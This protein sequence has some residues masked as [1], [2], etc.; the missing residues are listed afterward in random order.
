MASNNYHF[1][2]SWHL[3]ATV[4][5]LAEI[6]RDPQSLTDWWAQCFLA[7]ET[8]D[9][10][11]TGRVLVRGFLPYTLQ[12]RFVITE[13][14]YP[15]RIQVEVEGD[16]E[17]RYLFTVEQGDGFVTLHVDTRLHVTKPV[18]RHL[19]WALK[20]LF[21]ANHR[22]CMERGMAN[23]REELARRRARERSSLRRVTL[24]TPA[25]PLAA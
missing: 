16:F 1:R 2:E 7:V 14:A 15:H 10:G 18:I 25:L 8:R 19:S 11:R 13:F 21:R 3:Q 4:E 20:P 9:A 17:G 23:I 6:F 12:F 5:D 22:W 24:P